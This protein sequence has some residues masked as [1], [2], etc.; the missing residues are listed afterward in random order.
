VCEISSIN[1][2]IISEEQLKKRI[3]ELGTQI[4]ADYYDKNLM[5]IGVLKGCFVFMADL[6]REINLPCKIDFMYVSSYNKGTVSSGRVQIVKD[7]T[8]DIAGCDVLIVEDIL[9]TGLT[10]E[11][12]CKILAVR[13][14]ASIK[15]CTLLDKPARRKSDVYP[16][17]T[18]FEIEDKF[19]VGYGLDY[20]QEYRNLPYIGI[21]TPST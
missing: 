7:L 19:V 10:L 11:S 20:D 6:V 16:D 21:Y 15:I 18:G 2:I 1:E 13:N 9:D 17:Y 14:P 8:V 12:L 4:T 3:K 5:I